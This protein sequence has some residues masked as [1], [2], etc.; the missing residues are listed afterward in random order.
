[1]P[2]VNRVKSARALFHTKP[3]LDEDGKPKQSPV[4]VTKTVR[5]EETGEYEKVQVQK[6][7][8]SGRP[9]TRAVVVQDR[10]RPKPNL[11]CDFSGC[12]VGDKPGEILPGQPYKFLKLRFSQKNRHAEHP[13]WQHWEYSSSVAAQCAQ[14]Q[15]EMHSAID[16]F[17]FTSDEDFDALKQELQDMAQGFADEREEALG[18]MPE[19]LQDGSQAQEYAEAAE[20]WVGEFDNVSEP[21]ADALEDC[22]TCGG[23]GKDTCQVCDGSQ[24]DEEGNQCEECGGTGEVECEDCDE[25]KTPDTLSEDWIEEA[26]DALREAVDAAEF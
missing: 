17:E 23:E 18:N 19:S 25:G 20:S 11:R 12:A 5:N 14:L 1:M 4:M 21:S 10:D 6:T 15:Q 26:R 13:D 22:E 24:E 2:R 8:K 16:S 3:V 7:T 9:V